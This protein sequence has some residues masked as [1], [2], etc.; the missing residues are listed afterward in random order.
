MRRPIFHNGTEI[1]LLRQ[2]FKEIRNLHP[3]YIDAISV[4]PDH[5]HT[6]WTL[7]DG[8]SDY[9]RRW[10]LIKSRFSRNYNK[11]PDNLRQSLTGKGE[12]G[13]WQR[14]FWEHL[15]KTQEDFNKHCDYIHYNPVKHGLVEAPCE[16]QYSSFHKYVER[17]VYDIDWGHSIR[18]EVL[19]LNLE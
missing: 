6:I 19:D 2:C 5:L 9:S 3:F 7:P 10:K 17:G 18:K 8:D 11:K 4:L 13:I 12:K 15:I 16:W 1:K 14:R